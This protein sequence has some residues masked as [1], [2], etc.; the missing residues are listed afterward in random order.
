MAKMRKRVLNKRA[1]DASL[2]EKAASDVSTRQK[3]PLAEFYTP[4]GRMVT[5]PIDIKKD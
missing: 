2:W 4:L 3:Q 1:T 5:R